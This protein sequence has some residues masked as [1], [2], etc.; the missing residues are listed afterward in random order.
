MQ[1]Q[2][3]KQPLPFLRTAVRE[4]QNQEQTQEVKLSDAL[5]DIGRVLCAWGQVILRSKEWRSGSMACSGGMMVWVLY[6][7]ED[8]SQPKCVESWLPFQMNWDLG[9]ET[10]EGDICIRMLPR[11]V[12]ARSVSARKLMIRAGIGALGEALVR[13]EADISIPGE[14]P[15]DVQLLKATYPVRLNREAGEKAFALDEELTLPA[16]S[17]MPSKLIYYTLQPEITEKRITGNR[18]AF[19]G[20]GNLHVL[21]RSDEGQLH[22]WDFPIPFSQLG[23]LQA[24]YD[25]DAQAEVT[26]AVTN[27]ELDLDEA[28]HMRMKCGLLGQYRV[29]DRQ[30]LETVADAYSPVRT[31]IPQLESLELPAILETRQEMRSVEQTMPQDA[32]IVVDVNYLPDF[33]RQRRWEEEQEW[34][35]PG[36]FQTLWYGE[37]GNLRAGNVRSEGNFRMNADENTQVDAAVFPRGTPQGSAGNG[38]LTMRADTVLNLDTVSQQ[39]IPMVTGLEVEPEQQADPNRPSLILRKA[40]REPLWEIAKSTGST[41]EAIRAANALEAEPAAGQILLIPVS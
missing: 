15:E 31:V 25:S 8:G 9:G 7:P 29:S 14:V 17:P 37:D 6:A 18:V 24:A 26:M 23:D 20:N 41:M 16:S 38:T 12:D 5:P 39:G 35:L 32:D 3:Q 36:Q 10:R 34:E 4:V 27:L 1:L 11:F 30:M 19:R 33:P 40:G 28:G 13:D 22:S 21:Y 2:F